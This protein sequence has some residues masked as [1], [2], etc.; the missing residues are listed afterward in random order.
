MECSPE[1][2]AAIAKDHLTD[3]GMGV[4][5]EILPAPDHSPGYL[6]YEMMFS[7]NVGG[8][9]QA[10][11]TFETDPVP[12]TFP[13]EISGGVF[14]YVAQL[15]ATRFGPELQRLVID[16]DQACRDREEEDHDD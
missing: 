2:L 8:G 1:V 5:G 4:T 13:Q 6:S 15:L 11:I 3:V 16:Y 9:R 12:L 10:R 14:P 7:V